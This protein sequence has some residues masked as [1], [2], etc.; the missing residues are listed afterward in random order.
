M[1]RPYIVPTCVDG[2]FCISAAGCNIL[3]YGHPCLRA[4]GRVGAGEI[5]AARNAGSWAGTGCYQFWDYG[6]PPRFLD[7]DLPF[8]LIRGAYP[9]PAR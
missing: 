9:K 8:V 6:E 7:S 2:L 4:S 3:Q 5:L 1:K